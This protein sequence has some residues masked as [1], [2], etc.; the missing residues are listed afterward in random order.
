MPVHPGVPVKLGVH[1]DLLKSI[2]RTFK[3]LCIRE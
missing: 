2:R 1:V 3:C